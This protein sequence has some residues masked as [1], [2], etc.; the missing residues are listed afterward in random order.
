[1]TVELFASLVPQL[2]PITDLLYLHV[3]GEPLY[4]PNLGSFLDICSKYNMKVSIVTNGTL[5]S[6]R[7]QQLLMHQG[8]FQINFSLQSFDANFPDIDNE[9]Y[10][11]N[12]FKFSERCFY[13]RPDL[14]INF[15]LWNSENFELSLIQNK[16]VIDRIKNFFE[17]PAEVM[18]NLSPRGN[19]LKGDLYLNF[20]DRFEWP[21]MNMPFQGKFGTCPALKHQFGILSDGTVVPCCLD[22][23]GAL[24]LG[25]CREKSIEEILN[26]ERAKAVLNGFK[27]YNLVEPICQRCTYIQRFR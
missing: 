20:A 15:R 11:N 2:Q 10:L 12:I 18:E 22:K 14:Y 4:H 25:N 8:V 19:R 6:K 9:K 17:I 26:S 5:M 27:T 3:M 7:H 1:M 23:D 13:E 24:S 21:S 16:Q